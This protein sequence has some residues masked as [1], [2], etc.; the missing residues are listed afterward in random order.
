MLESNLKFKGSS[1]SIVL[2][3][4]RTLQGRM[5]VRRRGVCFQL[6]HCMVTGKILPFSGLGVPLLGGGGD[7]LEVL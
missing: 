2:G 4:L 5:E 1:L 6:C 3:R 7:V